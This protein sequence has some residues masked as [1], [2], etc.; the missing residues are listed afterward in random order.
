MDVCE[1]VGRKVGRIDGEVNE[2]LFVI[3]ISLT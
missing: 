1:E 3:F 2:F